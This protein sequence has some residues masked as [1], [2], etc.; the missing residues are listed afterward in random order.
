MAT[1][2]RYLIG[3]GEKLSVEVA[4]PPRGFG[5]KAHPYTFSEAVE[6]LSPQLENVKNELR[7]LPSL[8]CPNGETVV[9]ITLHP[10]YLAKS[11][12]RQT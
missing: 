9:G 8:A 5:D 4:R 3:G 7:S 1:T 11:Y 2:P 12:Y 10:T 6:R